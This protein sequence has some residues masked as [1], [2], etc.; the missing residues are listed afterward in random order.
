[1][2]TG[3]GPIPGGAARHCF[4]RSKIRVIGVHLTPAGVHGV[5]CWNAPIS[6]SHS[7]IFASARASASKRA[8][9]KQASSV[10]ITIVIRVPSR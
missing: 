6:A 4:D 5:G 10:S 7:T 3:A 8:A 9:S 1:M 2:P